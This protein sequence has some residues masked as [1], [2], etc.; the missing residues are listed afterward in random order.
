MIRVRERESRTSGPSEVTDNRRP[1]R[2]TVMRTKYVDDA[3]LAAT[4]S[5]S[6]T[7]LKFIQADWL[8]GGNGPVAQ[9]VVLGSGLDSRP[10]RLEPLDEVSWY[11]VDQHEVLRTRVAILK[12][13]KAALTPQ[14]SP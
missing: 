6:S 13:A 3:V 10:W 2:Q 11:E 9:V 5:T 12:S 1:V 7:H 8:E 4:G 14:V